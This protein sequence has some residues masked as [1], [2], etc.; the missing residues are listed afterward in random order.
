MNERFNT[1]DKFAFVVMAIVVALLC[2]FYET[3]IGLN[4]YVNSG[5]TIYVTEA[6]I[7]R[8]CFK[9]PFERIVFLM[10]DG[11]A[12]TYTTHHE[13]FVIMNYGWFRQALKK[14]GYQISDVI[15]CIHNHL[16]SPRFSPKDKDLYRWMKN[17]GFTGIF[18]LYH[19][20]TKEIII[21]KE[22]K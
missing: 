7:F 12:I 19:Q 16:S 1:N 17:D 20:V 21:Y 15:Y 4:G 11:N 9:E 6:S 13:P 22:H 10:K 3:F 2:A 8:A 14:R 5:D 18:A